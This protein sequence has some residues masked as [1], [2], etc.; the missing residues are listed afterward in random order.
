MC[1]FTD[2]I[3]RFRV[4]QIAL[5]A[6]N[7]LNVQNGLH[8][9]S[10][11]KHLPRTVCLAPGPLVGQMKHVMGPVKMAQHSHMA[12]IGIA[13]IASMSKWKIKNYQK[14][15]KGSMSKAASPSCIL[16]VRLNDPELP[17]H[18]LWVGTASSRWTP[19]NP[20]MCEPQTVGQSCQE[21]PGTED[22]WVSQRKAMVR[23]V[24]LQSQFWVTPNHSEAYLTNLSITP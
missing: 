19:L 14:D 9:G 4:R 18:R 15:S 7:A 22:F 5:N 13:I 3:S 6:L 1:G 21:T 8:P 10:R 20:S 24:N 16:R 12:S 11:K 23:M 2:I 17:P